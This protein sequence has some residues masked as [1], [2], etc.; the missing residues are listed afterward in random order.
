MRTDDIG[1]QVRSLEGGGVDDQSQE[2]MG[3]VLPDPKF[4][5]SHNQHLAMKVPIQFGQYGDTNN[6]EGLFTLQKSCTHSQTKAAKL[7]RQVGPLRHIW[8]KLF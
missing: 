5:R 8:Q 1:Y 4:R 6:E 2:D 3:I 7:F